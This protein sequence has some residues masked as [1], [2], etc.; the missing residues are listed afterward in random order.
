M[1]DTSG[2]FQQGIEQMTALTRNWMQSANLNPVASSTANMQKLASLASDMQ[3][4]CADAFQR[5][6]DPFLM[7]NQKIT[8]HVA[9]LTRSRDPQDFAD[10][11]F[12]IM[13]LVMED[14]SIRAAVWGE[15]ADKAGHRY[16]RFTREQ[17]EEI[18]RRRAESAGTRADKADTGKSGKAAVSK[19]AS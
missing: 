15:L 9:A 12:E 10:F 2:I 5:H 13:A 16:A 18:K 6:P 1:T 11:Q 14:A 19:R 8:G 17:A 7:G 3:A 4:L